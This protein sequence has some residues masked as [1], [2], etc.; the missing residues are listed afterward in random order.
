MMEGSTSS[1]TSSTDRRRSFVLAAAVLAVVYGC[2]ILKETIT[3]DWMFSSSSETATV[4]AKGRG[5]GGGGGVDKVEYK[6]TSKTTLL[7]S[8]PPECSFLSKDRIIRL[9]QMGRFIRIEKTSTTAAI[10]STTTISSSS[11]SSSFRPRYDHLSCFVMKARYNCA[12]SKKPRGDGDSATDYKL[13][14]VENN[15]DYN[16]NINN[17]NDGNF[18]D[19]RAIVDGW[20]GPKGIIQQNR[21]DQS[22][23]TYAAST[24]ASSTS[25][26]IANIVFH[27]NSYLRQL[28][29]AFVCGWRHDITNILVQRGV[30]ILSDS[31]YAGL[32]SYDQVGLDPI[33]NL[34]YIQQHGCRGAT[35]RGE[36]WTISSYYNPADN[37]EMTG[38]QQQQQNVQVPSNMDPDCHDDLAM[39]EFHN[40]IRFYFVFRPHR[41]KNLSSIYE[42]HFMKPSPLLRPEDIDVMVFN[43]E[44]ELKYP[45]NMLEQLGR[46]KQ[47][48]DNDN[49]NNNNKKRN[50]KRTSKTTTT[51]GQWNVTKNSPRNIIWPSILTFIQ[52][53]KDGEPKRWFGA[54]NPWITRPPDGH[55]CMPGVPDDEANLLLFALKYQLQIND[56]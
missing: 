5:R 6:T 54:N 27:G 23:T 26:T 12:Y 30:G 7:P 45:K 11:P 52:L 32:I 20:N 41:Y 22:T 29:E 21:H 10:N 28:L 4:G 34:S 24:T 47:F 19:L 44:M 33:T 2:F 35:K 14:L 8:L 13:V 48:K 25:T 18:C 53:Q 43:D 37:E 16:N 55:P 3:I 50:K 51:N 40:S 36:N 38:V 31:K 9:R 46:N 17:I 15:T 39:V 1:T 56:E 49:N 42:H